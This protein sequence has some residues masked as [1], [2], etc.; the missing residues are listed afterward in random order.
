MVLEKNKIYFKNTLTK[1]IEVFRPNKKKTV[2]MYHCGPT[3]YNRAHLGNLAAY[4]F[5]D[6]L[7]RFFEEIGYSVTQVINITDVGHLT[8]DADA[9]DDKMES[10]AQKTGE[11]VSNIS[12]KYTNL[13]ISDLKKL[14]IRVEKI[15][16]PRATDHIKEQIDMILKM[17]KAGYTYKTSDGIYYNTQKYSDYGILGGINIQGLK[18]GARVEINSEKINHT[19]FALWKFSPINEK[20]QQEWNSPWGIGFPGWHIECSAMAKK[21]LG[22]NFDIHT[23]GIEHIPIHHN[24]EIA[25]S[26]ATDNKILANYWLHINHLMLNGNKISKSLGNVVYIEDLER[27][28]IDASVFR[29]WFLTSHYSSSSNFSWEAIRATQKPFKRIVRLIETQLS[30]KTN[31]NLIQKL[32]GWATKEINQKYFEKALIALKHDMGT[33]EAIAVVSEIINDDSIDDAVKAKTILKIDKILGIGFEKIANQNITKRTL[34]SKIPEEIIN[35]AEERKIARSNREF[36]KADS[37][38]T[39]II[40]LGYEIIDK[41]NDYII[42]KGN[43]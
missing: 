26:V 2:G 24:N 42:S 11:K 13:F 33:P 5:A 3:V 20:R 41:D 36:I 15:I 21:Y 14:N 34:A 31:R 7:R 27:E 39:E 9:G 37:L 12:E 1:K 28:N 25:Q 6:V 17:E 19:D 35:L 38:R 32:F 29:Y 4:I 10:Q 22:P 8:D 40:N 16:F 43:S 23:G 30:R 18:E